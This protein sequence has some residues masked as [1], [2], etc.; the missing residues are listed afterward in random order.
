MEK[1]SYKRNRKGGSSSS[2]KN[3]TSSLLKKLLSH[4]KQKEGVERKKG[5]AESVEAIGE[6][7]PNDGRENPCDIKASTSENEKD[8]ASWA[9]LSALKGDSHWAHAGH[10]S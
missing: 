9:K 6:G 10:S 3:K 1:I 8:K 5:G 4:S 7:T 2:K